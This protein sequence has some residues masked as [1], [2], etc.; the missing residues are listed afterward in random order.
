M[1]VF[2]TLHVNNSRSHP[3]EWTQQQLHDLCYAKLIFM[4]S[5]FNWNVSTLSK[6]V[7]DEE[8]TMQNIFMNSAFDAPLLIENEI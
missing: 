3:K 7:I 6:R 8:S 5:S 4:C 2:Y 1:H